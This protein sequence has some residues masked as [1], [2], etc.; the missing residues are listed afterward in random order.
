M[1]RVRPRITVIPN[2]RPEAP[3]VFLAFNIILEDGFTPIVNPDGSAL[4]A[5]GHLN[6]EGL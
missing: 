5:E 6:G 1:I 4:M 2:P 3:D